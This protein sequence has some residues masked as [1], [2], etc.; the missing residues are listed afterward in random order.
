MILTKHQLVTTNWQYSNVIKEKLSSEL[1]NKEEE[2]AKERSWMES[3]SVLPPYIGLRSSS[4]LNDKVMTINVVGHPNHNA[5][6]RSSM[7]GCFCSD[8]YEFVINRSTFSD[9]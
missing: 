3:S 1:L 9:Q 8:G 5:N 2:I 7:I 4:V 6:H